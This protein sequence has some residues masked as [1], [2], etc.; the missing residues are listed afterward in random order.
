MSQPPN[1]QIA[2]LI[3][4]AV[5][6]VRVGQLGAAEAMLRRVLS[7]VR[8][9]PDALQ[10]LGL[11]RAEQGQLVEAEALYRR[12]LSVKPKQPHVQANL[13]RLLIATGRSADAIAPLRAAVRAR[14]DLSDTYFML[15]QAQGNVGDLENA[16]RNYRT[17][18]RLDP[19]ATAAKA[20]LGG[21]L[22]DLDRPKDGEEILRSA[23]SDTNAPPFLMAAVEHNLGV[24]LKRQRRYPEALACFDAALARVPDLPLA[25]YNRANTLVHLGRNE[26]AVAGYR[27][28][29][30]RDPDNIAVHHELNALLY[31]MGRDDEFL[32]SFEE[33]ARRSPLAAELLR[34]KGGLL[35]RAERCEE[36]L[37]C[38]DRAATLQG[39]TPEGLSGSALA[40]ATLGRLDDSIAAYERSLALRPNDAVTKVNL[41]TVLLRMD[42]RQRALRI[43]EEV[44]PKNPFDQGALAVHEVALRATGDARA[45]WLADYDRHIQVF[46]LEPPP[47]F[48]SVAEFN[49]ALNTHLDGLHTDLR[50][51]VD[52]TLRKGTQTLDS[53]FD[54]TNP[55]IDALQRRIEEA[56]AAYIRNMKDGDDHPLA[57]RRGGGFA[58]PGSWSSR[59]YD[60]GFHTNHIHPKG[61]ISSCYYV[62]VPD[63]AEDEQA[64]QGWIKFGEPAFDL[65]LRDAVQRTVKPVP[66]RLVLFPSYMWHGTVPFHAPTARTTIAF[67]AIPA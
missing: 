28:Y 52:Q 64:K 18:L 17:A 54:G 65:P 57:G 58:F 62:A 15:A 12:S 39:D 38:F 31:R 27:S 22:N 36:A 16:E 14:A 32:V 30:K 4:Q 63:A 1:S 25:G 48:S 19:N 13:G 44:V 2:A 5:Q 46:D 53:L 45:A 43:T 56:V 3:A 11:V 20:G 49:A 34:Q 67:D 50:E 41:A 42:E 61:W 66:G 29:L 21:L 24:S 37:E 51:H 59:L 10:L 7:A 33:A 6:S 35:V 23:L 55:L 9:E 60:H 8:N 40:L 26:D 47:G